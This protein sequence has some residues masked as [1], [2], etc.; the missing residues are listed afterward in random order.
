MTISTAGCGGA[1]DKPANPELVARDFRFEPAE[2]PATAGRQVTLTFTNRGK[3]T[4]NLS[5]PSIPDFDLDFEPGK[6]ETVIFVPPST[7]ELI[8]FVCKFHQ[9][10]GMRGAFRVQP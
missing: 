5:I 4:H 10:R 7:P 9:D 6:S 8:E 3:V 1:A 2:L